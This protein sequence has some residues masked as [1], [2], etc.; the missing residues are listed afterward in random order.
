MMVASFSP[1]P[2]VCTQGGLC[3]EQPQ[4]QEGGLA[5]AGTENIDLHCWGAGQGGGA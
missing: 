5:G 4:P 3:D 2:M 1:E